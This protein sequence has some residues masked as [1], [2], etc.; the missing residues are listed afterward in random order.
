MPTETIQVSGLIP[1][2][3]KQ[4]YDAWLDAA[5]HGKISGGKATIESYVGG[6][7]TAQDG[8]IRGDNIELDP[9]KKIVQSWKTTDFPKGAPASRL[10][11]TLSARKGI[12]TEISFVQT[13]IPEGQSQKYG[14]GWLDRYVT[15][16]RRYFTNLAAKKA[17]EKEAK[18]NAPA[19]VPKAKAEK[20]APKKEAKPAKKEAKPAKPAPKKA[21]KPAKPAPKPAKK[22]APKKAAKPAKKPAA[23]KAAKPAKKPKAAPK[24][25]KR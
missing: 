18:A 21:A 11:V 22:P 1:A 17:A 2:T 24:K 5:T 4:I 8:Y 3:P 15:P 9:G 20:P 19:P 13:G 10:E 25:K 6:K 23:K 12:G 14:E 7:F 16:M